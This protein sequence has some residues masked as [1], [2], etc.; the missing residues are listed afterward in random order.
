MSNTP[1]AYH[2]SQPHPDHRL[3]SRQE[4]IEWRLDRIAEEIA[5]AWA[6][7]S[8]YLDEL[9]EEEDFFEDELDDPEGTEMRI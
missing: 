6:E 4:L 5:V 9:L 2:S 3:L 1:E 8:K 7:N